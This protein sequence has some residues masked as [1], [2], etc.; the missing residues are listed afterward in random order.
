MLPEY[1]LHSFSI[2]VDDSQREKAF[3]VSS[4]NKKNSYKKKKKTPNNTICWQSKNSGHVQAEDW[5][6]MRGQETSDCSN[7]IIGKSMVAILE[8]PEENF[9]LTAWHTVYVDSRATAHMVKKN[10]IIYEGN[11]SM[12]NTIGSTEI[13]VFEAISQGKSN[14]RLLGGKETVRLNHVIFVR[15]I[16]HNLVS[17][18]GLLD[19]DHILFFT[20]TDC[21]KV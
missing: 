11:V 16:T 7:D 8:S 14:I 10:L 2:A 20:K 17:L 13:D 19:D 1:Y 15:K 5:K 6:L 9:A 18:S 21:I 12:N 4:K 3:V